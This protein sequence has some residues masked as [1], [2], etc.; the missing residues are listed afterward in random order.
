MEA[1]D[2][3]AGH[4]S[5]SL[6]S[7]VLHLEWIAISHTLVVDG[8]LVVPHVKRAD[9]ITL[10]ALND[11]SA[12]VGSLDELERAHSTVDLGISRQARIELEGDAVGHA[13]LSSIKL[14]YREHVGNL[15]GVSA[16]EVSRGG[17]SIDSITKRSNIKF[18]LSD[19]GSVVL[20]IE[21]CRIDSS[22]LCV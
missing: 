3:G 17:H 5:R 2:W 8:V 15:L 19:F 18:V 14:A 6:N 22:L 12:G 20:D 7:R 9:H 4:D 1:H 16:I 10:A 11:G 21:H 13:E